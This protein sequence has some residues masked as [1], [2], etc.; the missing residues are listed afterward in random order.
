[1]SAQGADM[2]T[3]AAALGHS[4]TGVTKKHYANP[5]ME[6]MKRIVDNVTRIK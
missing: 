4:T 3:I 5:S 6:A 2:E 1:M